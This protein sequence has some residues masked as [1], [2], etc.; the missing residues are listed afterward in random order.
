MSIL[1]RFLLLLLA[2]VL[3]AGSA[4]AEVHGTADEAKALAEKAV[5]EIKSVGKDKA[6]DEFTAKDGK[7][8]DRDL[9]VFVVG[10]DGVTVAHGSNKALVGKPM[11]ELKDMNGKAFIKD[12]AELAKTKGNGWVEYMFTN[13][14]SKK[15][16]AKSSYVIR[17]PNYDGFVGVGIYK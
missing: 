1:K 16:E 14:Q 15:V 6:F 8:Q 2:Q 10:F 5:A 4:F 17:I 7:W 11:F 3:I 9:Y 13:P 12:M